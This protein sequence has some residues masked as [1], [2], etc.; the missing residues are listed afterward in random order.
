MTRGTQLR[1]WQT[2]LLPKSR[3]I[4]KDRQA[5]RAAVH[6]VCRVGHIERLNKGCL[7]SRK[8]LLNPIALCRDLSRHPG[9]S[10]HHLEQEA[11]P[12][13]GVWLAQGATF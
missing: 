3:E 8:P 5:W 10:L 13:E 12:G 1:W 11:S 7:T 6:G 4:V 2:E 9:Q